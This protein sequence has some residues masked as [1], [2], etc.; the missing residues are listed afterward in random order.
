MPKKEEMAIPFV[1]THYKNFDSKSISIPANS[2][3]LNVKDS[4]LKK[5]FDKCQVIY[6]LKQTKKYCV[7]WVNQKF[8]IVS[9]KSMVYIAMNVKIPAALFKLI[10]VS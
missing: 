7:C 3:L 10:L 9:L 5:V 1:S 6:A 8:K 4:K 2:L